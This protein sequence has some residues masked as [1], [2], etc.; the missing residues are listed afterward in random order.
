[1]ASYS[2]L[3]D[4]SGFSFDMSKRHIGF[5]PLQNSNNF[6]CFWSLETA[7][8]S[9]ETK[10]NKSKI[11]VLYG[12]LELDSL[13]LPYLNSITSAELGKREAA[14]SFDEGV[15]RFKKAVL[16]PPDASLNLTH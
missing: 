12:Q 1:M 16:I 4:Y 9:F 8:G 15:V 3:L 5:S 14:F 13:A 7:W 2:L 6:N 11:K 10:G